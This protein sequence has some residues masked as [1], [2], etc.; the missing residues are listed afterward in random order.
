MVT[1]TRILTGSSLAF[2]GCV[3]AAALALVSEQALADAQANDYADPTTWLCRPD[4]D[5]DACAQNLD[6]T[7]ISSDGSIEVER[8]AADPDAAIDCFY[9][10]PTV[11]TDPT[12]NADMNAGQEELSVIQAQFARF[13]SQCRTFAPLYRQVTLTA[14]RAGMAG[15]TMAVDRALGYNDVRDAWHHYLEH[16][17]DGRGVVLIGHSQGAGVLTRLIRDEIEGAEVQSQLVSALIIGTSVNV[18]AGELSGGSFRELPLCTDPDQYG[19]VVAFA[20]F[21][22]DVPPPENSRFARAMGD[23]MAAAC[24]NPASLTGGSGE[25]HAY[26]STG[27]VAVAGGDGGTQWLRNGAAIDTPFVS[28]P[29]LLSAQC[30][31]DGLFNYLSVTTH[32]DADSPR[33]DRIGGDVMGADGNVMA[34]WGLHLIDMHLAMG[35]LVE[36]VGRQASAWQAAQHEH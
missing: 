16:Y 8:F 17:N 23:G 20:S 22:D 21:R 32:G 10:Y 29:G 15:E 14:L 33:T 34:D 12:P 18:A 26:L 25:L 2:A 4:V 3:A 11:S 35:N 7:V 30:V 28:V 1:I 24:T 6:T 27:S 31:E 19:C 13:G 9:V 36:L 5:D